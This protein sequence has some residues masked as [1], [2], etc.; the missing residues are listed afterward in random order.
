MSSAMEP[1]PEVTPAPAFRVHDL[2]SPER[3]E[4]DEAT[5]LIKERIASMI[6]M[7]RLRRRRVQIPLF[8]ASG[9][10]VAIGVTILTIAGFAEW[11]GLD[12]TWG[13]A[14]VFA[15]AA[16]IALAA[17]PGDVILLR[18]L[19]CAVGLVALL[20]VVVEVPSDLAMMR[21]VTGSTCLGLQGISMGKRTKLVSQIVG[22]VLSSFLA[23]PFCLLGALYLLAGS[24]AGAFTSLRLPILVIRLLSATFTIV[25]IAF[26]FVVLALGL[27]MLAPDNCE[28]YFI[29]EGFVARIQR[30]GASSWLCFQC[31]AIGLAGLLR[32]DL[33]SR[34]HAYFA[35]RGVGV[36][37]AAGIAELLNGVKASHILAQAASSFRAVSLDELSTDC[38]A[39]PP[40]RL[41]SSRPSFPSSV[42]E[43]VPSVSQE[44]TDVEL[45]ATARASRAASK[46]S[47]AL[48]EA[49]AL[50]FTRDSNA[51]AGV[52]RQSHC[53]ANVRPVSLGQADAF[54]SHSWHDPADAKWEALCAWSEEFRARHGRAPLLWIDKECIEQTNIAAQLQSLPVY[55]AGCQQLLVLHGPTYLQRLWCVALSLGCAPLDVLLPLP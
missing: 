24:F 23:A 12:A 7:R 29:P 37:A 54:V 34:V 15:G 9:T 6:A 11:T 35:M 27:S 5:R 13:Y 48:Q 42:G 49:A 26:G 39:R 19:L 38:F 50:T 25:G 45:G 20:I 14:P 55:L 1:A 22:A 4:S 41:S 31:V 21:L 28:A 32:P 44:H 17:M 52:P 40:S 16:S 2:A 8:V 51:V 30:A 10:L 47:V 43:S 33:C 46:G 3:P 36:D 53:L 18:S